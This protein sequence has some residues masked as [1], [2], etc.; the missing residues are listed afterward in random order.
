M[1]VAFSESRVIVHF[2]NSISLLIIWYEIR[3]FYQLIRGSV[4]I[5]ILILEI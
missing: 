2:I 5:D 1:A 3:N 4:T